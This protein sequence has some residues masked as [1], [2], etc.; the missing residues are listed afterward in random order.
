MVFPS[1][2][3]SKDADLLDGIQVRDFEWVAIKD[4]ETGLHSGFQLT[5]GLL[6]NGLWLPN[7]PGRLSLGKG[8]ARFYSRALR[9]TA[10]RALFHQLRS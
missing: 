2:A 6:Q 5:H 10:V 3:V 9:N 8:I 4:N 1:L 7:G